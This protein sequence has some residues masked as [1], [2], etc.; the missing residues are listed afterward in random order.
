MSADN[1]PNSAK[2]FVKPPL[3]PRPAF[4]F[5]AWHYASHPS[6]GLRVLM[7]SVFCSRRYITILLTFYGLVGL[8][9]G[10]FALN[11]PKS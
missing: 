8:V 10:V 1:Q 9:E 2:F 11:V 7:L 6:A 4:T 3:P 5:A